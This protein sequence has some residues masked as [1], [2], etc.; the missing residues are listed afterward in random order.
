MSRTEPSL[1][2]AS[3]DPE[4]L[5]H[6]YA[7][8]FEGDVSREFSNNHYSI[9]FSGTFQIQIYRPSRD[10]HLLQSQKSAVAICFK[11]QTSSKS[12]LILS[13]W[14]HQ[15]V[16]LGGEVIDGPYDEPFGLETW[17]ADPEGNNFLIMVPHS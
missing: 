5:A 9:S 16:Q 3:G 7:S 10:T 2:I 14:T 6:F 17:M 13:K 15:I 4:K 8:L 12:S 11:R 1:L